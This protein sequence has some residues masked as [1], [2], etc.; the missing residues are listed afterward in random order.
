[1]NVVFM[2]TPDFA[3][4]SLKALYNGGHCIK[5]VFT[6]PDK[7]RGRKKKLTPPDVKVWAIEH[8]IPVYQPESVRHGEADPILKELNPDVIVVAAYGNILPSSVLEYPKYG[9]INVHGSILPEYRGAAPIQW[10]VLD[11]K[12]KT[13]ITTMQMD[14]G[15]DTGDILMVKETEIGE[16][17]TSGELFDRLA[18]LGGEVLLE[19]L[20]K[21]ETI[22]P[23]KQD[24]SKS[25]YASMLSKNNSPIDWN[26]TAAKIHNQVRGLNPWPTATAVFNGKPLKIH[27][28]E[29]VEKPLFVKN[30]GKPGKLYAT[31]NELFVECGDGKFLKINCLQPHGSKKMDAPSFLNGHPIDEETILK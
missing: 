25:S 15:L 2:G 10:A 18:V 5:G 3:V 26:K 28:T 7:P 17:E 8:N 27:E 6:Q 20:L 23:I 9:C 13:G 29:K 12:E 11:G 30:T 1:M 19:T 16:N 4:E 31:K 14:V 24:N 21:I 22:K